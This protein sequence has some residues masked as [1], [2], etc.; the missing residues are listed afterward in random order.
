MIERAAPVCSPGP[1]GASTP[2]LPQVAARGQ[3]AHT[4]DRLPEVPSEVTNV[5]GEQVGSA[6]ADRRAQDR[7]VHIAVEV[8]PT[9]AA[10]LTVVHHDVPRTE[11]VGGVR[12]ELGDLYAREPKSLLVEFLVPE[13][14]PEEEVTIAELVVT[15]HVLTSTGGVERQEVLLPIRLPLSREGRS[16]PEVRR[17]LRLV[18]AARTRAA[19]LEDQTRGDYRSGGRRLQETAVH[20]RQTGDPGDEELQEEIRDLE[21]MAERFEAHSVSELDRKYMHQRMWNR[22]HGK[23]GSTRRISRQRAMRPG[24]AI[25]YRQGDATRPEGFDRKLIVHICDELGSW[26]GFARAL[27][28]RWPGVEAQF[29]A[30]QRSTV[31]GAPPFRLGSV[32]VVQV[33]PEVWVANMLA[34]R[35]TRGR[36]GIPTVDY[37]A[38]D[39]ALARVAE[40]ALALGLSVHLP[41]IGCSVAGGHWEVIEEIIDNRICAQGIPVT[42]YDLSPQAAMW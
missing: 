9:A 41:R 20:L 39:Q 33:E 36:P 11:I 40:E 22:D 38:L 14:E 12:L 37:A 29:E 32:L 5:A 7:P 18:Q 35:G 13:S 30:W 19:A 27:S 31:P 3:D 1:P 15:A 23:P 6:R 8:R 10:R 2:S 4:P 28:R 24:G 25:E 16:E 34:K 17:E 42:V 21:A 26:G